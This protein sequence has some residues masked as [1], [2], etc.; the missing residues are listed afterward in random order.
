MQAVWMEPSSRQLRAS[1]PGF[2]ATKLGGKEVHGFNITFK[3][4]VG[5]EKWAR[6]SIHKVLSIFCAMGICGDGCCSFRV[7]WTMIHWLVRFHVSKAVQAE[8]Q[9]LYLG[10]VAFR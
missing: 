9:H 5:M 8:Y 2:S 4:S 1:F 6:S 7:C 10:G 3:T